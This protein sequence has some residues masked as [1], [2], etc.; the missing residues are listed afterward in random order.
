MRI[1]F[2]PIVL[3]AAFGAACTTSA[4]PAPAP[5]TTEAC[6][7]SAVRH[8]DLSGVIG[9][10]NHDTGNLWMGDPSFAAVLFYARNGNPDMP[11][12]GTWPG[13]HAAKILWWV[14]DASASLVVQ[15]HD[16]T[17][18]RFSQTFDG[19]GGQYAT[20]VTVPRP[21]CWT[22]DAAVAGRHVGSI[23]VHVVPP[24]A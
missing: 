22:L 5:R 13:G 11:A 18:R 19:Q 23:T 6:T 1:A 15:G 14:A 8:D 17:G 9:G 21:G 24:T 16:M 2:V 10:F 20:I 3:V 12:G 4:T 7:I